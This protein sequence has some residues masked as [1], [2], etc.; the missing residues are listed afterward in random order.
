MRKVMMIM[1]KLMM[2]MTR[3]MMT[4]A[5]VMMIMTKVPALTEVERT[6]NW[7]RRLTENPEKAAEVITYHDNDDD[8]DD[9]IDGD[10]DSRLASSVLRG[11]E[12]GC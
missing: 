12:S 2:T 7:R 9:D 11:C 8:Y 1:T 4:I 6:R 10:D 3:V 5:K